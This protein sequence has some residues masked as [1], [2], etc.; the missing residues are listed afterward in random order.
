[1]YLEGEDED[2]CLSFVELLAAQ[3][4]RLFFVIPDG[5][6]APLALWDLTVFHFA[7]EY[8]DL[9]HKRL[10][11]VPRHILGRL[12]RGMNRIF[13]GMLVAN[14]RQLVLATSGSDSQ[15][16]VSRI[17]ETAISVDPDRGQKIVLDLVNGRMR[18]A[19]YLDRDTLVPLSLDLT[20]VMNSCAGVAEGALAQ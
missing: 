17:E 13:T 4:Q 11:S 1:M 15:S 18:L 6:D 2:A 12:V 8:L 16:K 14:E 5:G 10:R 20:C 3:R 7:G 9:I 19:V